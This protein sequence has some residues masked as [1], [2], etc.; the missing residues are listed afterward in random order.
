M[1]A[2][3]ALSVLALTAALAV[4]ADSGFTGAMRRLALWLLVA[5]RRI[6]A[7][8]AARQARWRQGIQAE[9]GAL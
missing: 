8:H 2:V 7:R 6:D 4:I 5:A 3:A 9:G 1:T